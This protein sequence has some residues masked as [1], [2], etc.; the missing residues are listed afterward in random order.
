MWN[1]DRQ[2]EAGF[3]V[4]E[5]IMVLSTM[6]FM[7]SLS[8]SAYRQFN[9]ALVV[10]KAATVLASDL[11]LTRSYAIQRRSNVAFVARETELAYEIRDTS[12]TILG[13][14]SFDS[15]SG[16]PLDHLDVKT[17][18]DSVTFNSRGLLVVGGTAEVEV[19]RAA[20]RRS[21]QVNALGRYRI[22]DVGGGGS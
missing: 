21:V 14:R 19:G 8:Y 13:R 4:L 3:T 1:E 22:E 12:G 17:E 5:L 18:G 10:K 6:A 2:G 11:A 16:L 15:E 9:E 20:R 7:L